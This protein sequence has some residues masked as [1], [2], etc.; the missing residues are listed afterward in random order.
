MNKHLIKKKSSKTYLKK[1]SENLHKNCSDTNKSKNTM[2]FEILVIWWE[3]VRYE[4]H[5]AFID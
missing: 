3:F 4:S 2:L 5:N 1:K